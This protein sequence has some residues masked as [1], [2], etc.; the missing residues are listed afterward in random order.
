MVFA[1]D[2]GFKIST[3]PDTVRAPDVA[4]VSRGRLGLIGATG[5]AELAPDLVVEIVS[6]SDAPAELL[7]KVA[8]WLA[9]GTALV[10]VVDPA[11]P[12]V[13][14][15]RRDGSLSIAHEE[16]N[17]DGESVLPGFTCDVRALCTRAATPSS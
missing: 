1:Q 15:Y 12:E 3:A 10:W 6:P 8:E 5:Y 17:L 2:T 4:F 13:R 7:A 16:D 14:I 9:A 11:R